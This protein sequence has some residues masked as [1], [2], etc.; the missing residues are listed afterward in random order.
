MIL[1]NDKKKK[2]SQNVLETHMEITK[3]QVYI[4]FFP[5]YKYIATRGKVIKEETAK[6]LPLSYIYTYTY[7]Q[8]EL[9]KKKKKK[10][11]T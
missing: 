8:I 4:T 6:L 2:K 3:E 10:K 11:K 1:S 7:T 9:K 5:G